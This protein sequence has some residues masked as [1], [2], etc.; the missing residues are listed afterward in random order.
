MT[1]ELIKR[2]YERGLWS[3]DNVKMALTKNVITEEQYRRIIN[4]EK[5]ENK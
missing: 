2:N 5:S 3:K 1:F 4:A